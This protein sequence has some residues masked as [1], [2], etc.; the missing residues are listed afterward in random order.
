MMKMMITTELMINQ[1][2]HTCI[3]RGKLS[4]FEGASLHLQRC[5]FQNHTILAN[6]RKDLLVYQRKLSKL[7]DNHDLRSFSN[8]RKKDKIMG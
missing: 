1:R 2:P 4:Q 6:S 7:N 3:T 8:I 5:P